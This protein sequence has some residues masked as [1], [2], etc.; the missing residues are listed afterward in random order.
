M[1]LILHFISD[2]LAAGDD[3]EGDAEG[4]WLG[5][6]VPAT[7]HLHVVESKSLEVSQG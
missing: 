1:G 6:L 3:G 4:N 2:M 7:N 5:T